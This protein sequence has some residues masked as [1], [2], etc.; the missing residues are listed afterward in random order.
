MFY[1]FKKIC[2]V[3]V[4]LGILML[5]NSS[6]PY[7]KLYILSVTAGDQNRK[8]ALVSFP[9]PPELLKKQLYL[10][11]EKGNK[12]PMQVN[13]YQQGFFFMN[14]IRAGDVDEYY[15][16][17][18]KYKGEEVEVKE[19]RKQIQF[20]A[21]GKPVITY[22]TQGELP[23][24]D[25]DSVYLRGG[26]IHPVFTPSGKMVSDDYPPNHIHHHGIWSAWTKTEFM[27]RTPDF[28]NVKDGTGKVEAVELEESF[29][30][31]VYSGF[32]ARH[33]YVDLTS[34]KPL[35]ALDEVWQVK[36]Y[37]YPDAKF[38]VFDLE[39]IQNCATDQPLV[40]PTYHY[41]GVGFRGNRQWDGE[42]N[43]IFLTSEGKNRKEGHATKARWCHIGGKVDGS[44]A[45]ITIMDH[46]QN[47]RS[48]QAMRIHPTEPFFCYAPSQDG[49]WQIKPGEF[50]TANYR[51]VV[52]DGEPDVNTLDQLWQDFANPPTVRLIS[53]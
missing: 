18:G 12:I 25:I 45:G 15:I 29:Q 34:G 14:A 46:P 50:Y 4:L 51:F 40:L 37:N 16:E 49:N 5:Y 19:E 30:G 22:H 33:A 24:K 42:Q 44:M 17:T 23:R 20:T 21:H 35:K 26:Y 43:T 39:V 9:V 31:P 32:T 38:H 11:D 36:V 52:Y 3:A 2:F 7:K 10:K 6:S 28:W 8:S 48:P 47:F 27:G 1:R 53:K 13:Q 41:G